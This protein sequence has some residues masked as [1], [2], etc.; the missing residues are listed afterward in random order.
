MSLKVTLLSRSFSG[1]N[2]VFK[3]SC[4]RLEIGCR[5]HVECTKLCVDA[6]KLCVDAW[7]LCVD[8]WKLFMYCIQFSILKA[9]QNN[10][11]AWWLLP[12]LNLWMCGLSR[13]R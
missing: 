8:A 4:S 12:M 1:S 10:S 5:C 2:L 7:K 9:Q 11:Y 6:W 13:L 3:L